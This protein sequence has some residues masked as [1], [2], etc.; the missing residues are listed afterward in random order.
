MMIYWVLWHRN[1]EPLTVEHWLATTKI[2]VFERSAENS[3]IF[4]TFLFLAMVGS[5]NKDL[6]T[7]I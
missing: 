4:S 1:H 6:L 7:F 3:L 2:F 5:V